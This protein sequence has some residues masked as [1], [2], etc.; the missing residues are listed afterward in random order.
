MKSAH[1]AAAQ[2][3]FILVRQ[4]AGGRLTTP[5]KLEANSHMSTRKAVWRSAA[6]AGLMLASAI[7]ATPALAAS[8]DIALLQSYMGSYR[9]VGQVSGED[10]EKITCRMSIGQGN[11]D[12]INYQGRCLLAGANLSIAG[13][14]AYN[15]AKNQYE[16]AMTSNTAFSGMAVGR[17]QGQSVVFK[18]SQRAL[19]QGAD[20]SIAVGIV[21]HNGVVDVNFQVIDAATGRTTKA[22]VPF[23]KV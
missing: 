21:L 10:S 7:V 2:N 3:I 4:H 12:K 18:L 13:T 5:D 11:D 6:L 23:T 19:E 15:D 17:R 8:Q 14:I 22:T 9:G 20:L 1:L 16:A